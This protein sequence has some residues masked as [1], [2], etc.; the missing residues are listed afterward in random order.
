MIFK[1]ILYLFQNSYAVSADMFFF[2]I[3]YFTAYLTNS[4]GIPTLI[5]IFLACSLMCPLWIPS[6]TSAFKA[7]KFYANPIE[8]IIQPNYLAFGLFIKFKLN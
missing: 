2:N 8:A 5:A 7:L 4:N 1:G 6:E 3:I